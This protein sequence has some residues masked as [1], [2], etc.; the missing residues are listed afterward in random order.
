MIEKHI[1]LPGFNLGGSLDHV[2]QALS[3]PFK[4]VGEGK[5]KLEITKYSLREAPKVHQLF[6]ARKISGKV[7]LV[8]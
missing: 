2:P 7:V 8:P 4:L 3:A 6:E 1:S 5:L